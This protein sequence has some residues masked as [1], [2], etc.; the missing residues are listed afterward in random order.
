MDNPVGPLNLITDV[1]GLAVGNAGDRQLVSGV[2]VILPD[3]PVIAAVD[4]RGGA[5]GSRDIELLKPSASVEM[6]DAVVLSGGSA[7]GL[8]AAGGVMAWLAARGRGF[9]VG[10]VRV[11]IVPQAILFDLAGS[12]VPFEG[13]HSP[14]RRLG[15]AAAAAAGKAFRLGSA[16]AGTGAR[17]G[18]L[19][20]GLGSAS[21]VAGALGVTVGA[22]VAANP[23]GSVLMPGSG[24][25]WA[26][27][28]ER[29]GEFGGRR[30]DGSHDPAVVCVP[31]TAAPGAN[32]TIGAVATDA[33]L[34]R[35]QAARLA[36]I[37]QAGLARAVRPAHSPLDG[38]MILALSTGR[39]ALAS[40]DRDLA[41]LGG[42]AANCLARAVA[43]GVHAAR[44]RPGV[45]AYT[46]LY[47]EPG[48]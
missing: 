3:R 27:D 40:P 44:G 5:T 22:I 34:T 42:H 29:D 35:P 13:G 45:P 30:P 38:D 14:Y 20:G 36:A 26:W 8:D 4:V 17:A 43:R 41:V 24:V 33:A 7:F 10:R 1:P 31:R 28:M 32:T 6:I 11:P 18:H 19:A 2:T 23:V 9:P 37:A 25:F 39:V 12:T 46:D 21:V 16:G 48:A 15:R 47:P